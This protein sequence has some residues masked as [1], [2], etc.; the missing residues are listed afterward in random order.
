VLILAGIG[1]H[2][3]QAAALT[4]SEFGAEEDHGLDGGFAG[5]AEHGQ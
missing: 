3:L 1:R 2:F 5:E 4:G